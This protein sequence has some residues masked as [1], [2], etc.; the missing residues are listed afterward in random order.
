MFPLQ[1]SVARVGLICLPW[2]W[3]PVPAAQANLLPRLGRINLTIHE[4]FEEGSSQLAAAHR[5]ANNLHIRSREHV[6]RREL[7]FASGDPFNP[8]LLAQTERNLRA[9]PFLRDSRV[10][11]FPMDTDDD[12]F[13]DI[14]DVQ[15][16]VWDAWS[17]SPE[18]S[19]AK[20]ADRS[21]WKLGF[22]E[23]N[24]FGFGKEL[25]VSNRKGLDRS[26]Q[27]F[28]YRDRQL[29]GTHTMLTVLGA[30]NSDG[31]QGV[32][33]LERPFLSLTDEWGFALRVEA[34]DRRDPLYI[35]GRQVSELH[36]V[37]RLADIELTRTVTRRTSRAVRL[38]VAYRSRE[39]QVK[40]ELRDFGIVEIGLSSLQHRFV[41]LSHVNRFE[42]TEDV[43]LGAEF[44]ASLGVSTRPLGGASSAV[45]FSLAHRR[46]LQFDAKDFLFGNVSWAG[47]RQYD[48][49]ENSV[50]QM[51]LRYLRKHSTRH[52]LLAK[53]DFQHGTNLD[54]EVQFLI[55]AETGLRGYPVRRFSGTR[56]LLLSTEERWFVADDIA[57][58]VSL[59]VATF[60]DS[61]FAW[62]AGERLALSDLKSSVGIGLL[63]GRNRLSGDQPAIR[64]DAAYALDP[65]LGATRWVFISGS[66]V[67]F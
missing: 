25:G 13:T 33:S 55:G 39:D 47:R 1:R 17:T 4:V 26:G 19:F 34:F 54:A 35:G 50:L 63:V 62:P 16:T 30:N 23:T 8:E 31:T 44:S 48:R 42:R 65:L 11:A 24:T 45:L 41:E 59:G 9:L 27:T 52:A 61:G 66:A 28:L 57:Q 56:S 53:V 60:V 18:I 14:V 6:I 36:H 32:L 10:E 22:S 46:G 5:I 67:R 64:F 43:N 49:M 20:I 51:S 12:G 29:A 37:S 15:V 40:R 7:L 21:T 2:L 58:L 38:H 3:S